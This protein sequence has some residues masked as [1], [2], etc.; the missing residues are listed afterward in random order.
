M[1][2]SLWQTDCGES[3][4]GKLVDSKISYSLP[5][6]KPKEQV[7]IELELEMTSIFCCEKHQ[8]EQVL[9]NN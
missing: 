1:A 6:S 8:P 9:H 5:G 4:Y 7:Y 3:A 2:N